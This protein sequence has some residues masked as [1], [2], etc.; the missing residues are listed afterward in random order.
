MSDQNQRLVK[1]TQSVFFEGNKIRLDLLNECLFLK[2]LDHV[3]FTIQNKAA[4]FY[5]EDKSP[6]GSLRRIF[7]LGL[8]EGVVKSSKKKLTASLSPGSSRN[9]L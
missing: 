9:L 8:C 6:F 2:L 3:S 5:L 7:V 1:G 4:L